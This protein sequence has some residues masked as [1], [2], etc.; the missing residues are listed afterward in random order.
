MMYMLHEKQFF[1]RFGERHL[2]AKSGH[3]LLVH[4]EIADR[5]VRQPEFFFVNAK[6]AEKS[7]DGCTGNTK[8]A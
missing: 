4:D 1:R 7:N 6:T 8:K 2:S 5:L 3:V